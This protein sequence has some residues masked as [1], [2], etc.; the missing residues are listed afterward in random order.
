MKTRNKCKRCRFV[1]CEIS[2][3]MKRKWV[4]EQYI[5]KVEKSKNVK[6]TYKKDEDDCRTTE[7]SLDKSVYKKKNDIKKVLNF[8][9][10]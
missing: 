10:Y 1:K 9:R 4:L 3:G 6:S 2:A 8:R 7:N 5:P